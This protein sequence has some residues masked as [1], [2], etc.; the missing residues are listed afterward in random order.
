MMQQIQILNLGKFYHKHVFN[1]YME[2]EQRG[3]NNCKFKR[4]NFAKN[5]KSCLMVGAGAGSVT[6]RWL[7]LRGSDHG[8]ETEN[9]SRDSKQEILLLYFRLC[10]IPQLLLLEKLSK[11]TLLKQMEYA[12]QLKKMKLLP[13][14]ARV[15]QINIS[16]VHHKFIL[17]CVCDYIHNFVKQ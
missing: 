10:L 5:I 16:R 7:R 11:Q 2:S 14:V 15:T 6:S 8:S 9:I 1:Q 17:C 4:F 13:I 12:K 3:G